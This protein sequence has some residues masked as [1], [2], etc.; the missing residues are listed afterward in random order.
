[1]KTHTNKENVETNMQNSLNDDLLG[2]IVSC[3]DITDYTTEEINSLILSLGCDSPNQV[4]SRWDK[5]SRHETIIEGTKITRKV[6]GKYIVRTDLRLN[7]RMV[8]RNGG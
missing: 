7:G 8:T 1:M 4:L 5:S 3:L 2:L 6:N